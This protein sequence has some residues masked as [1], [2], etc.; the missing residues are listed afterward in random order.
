MD[1]MDLSD[2]V[3]K[4]RRVLAIICVASDFVVELWLGG[5]VGYLAGGK[6]CARARRAAAQK[7]I[8]IDEVGEVRGPVTPSALSAHGGP[9]R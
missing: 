9:R 1:L 7:P 6:T 3:K 8:V 5:L 4:W 2:I